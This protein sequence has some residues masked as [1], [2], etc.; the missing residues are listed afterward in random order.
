M[1]IEVDRNVVEFTP[2]NPQ[3]EA[4]LEVLWK[5][6]I[7]CYGENK[8]LVPIGQ[9]VPGQDKLARFTIEGV[10]GGKTTYSDK[11]ADDDCS[12]YCSIC[13]KYINL[14]TG[15]PIPLCCGK[16]MEKLD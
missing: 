5:V 4:A 6:I 10:P 12:Y 11:K 7:D 13:N 14:K 16:E 9:Y 8:K 2:E 1:K 15:D 3:E